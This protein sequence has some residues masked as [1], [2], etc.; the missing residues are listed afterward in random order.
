MSWGT[1]IDHNILIISAQTDVAFLKKCLKE[2]K[3][4]DEVLFRTFKMAKE[5]PEEYPLV[6]TKVKR[7]RQE[8][9]TTH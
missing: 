8:E 2:R 6:H 5:Y 7:S 1:K 9:Q 3:A 4:D